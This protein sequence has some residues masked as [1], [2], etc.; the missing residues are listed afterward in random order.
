MADTG[1]WQEESLLDGLILLRKGRG[2]T[3]DRLALSPALQRILSNTPRDSFDTMR[4]RMV[5]AIRSL[6]EAERTLLLAIFG[7][8]GATSRLTTL[9][10]RRQYL[11]RQLQRGTDTVASRE[12]AALVHLRT[13]LLTGRYSQSPL[14][15][16]VPEMHNGL[17]F[18]EIQ[19]YMTI[20]DRIWQS[21]IENYQFVATFDEIQFVTITRS[22]PA[23]CSTVKGGE[24][25]VHTESTRQGF[26]DQFTHVDRS[27]EPSDMIRGHDYD[28][29]FALT[30]TPGVTGKPIWTMG[31]EF[32]G[33]CLA[34]TLK[35]RF[36]GDI[37]HQIW[38]YEG[39]SYFAQ[40]GEPNAENEIAA[41]QQGVVSLHLRDQYGGL[42]SGFGWKW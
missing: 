6:D 15:I 27:G 16:D 28:L 25:R 33:R 30:P 17:I 31:R 40:P 9:G 34:A 11:G 42:M 21:T 26:N 23:V 39:L 24:F 32:H 8:T 14:T 19:V 20:K 3:A 4:S 18:E 5:S 2:F 22:Y 10:A 41:N 29:R 1:G 36:I 7:L 37:P 35:I 13:T 38:I 12:H